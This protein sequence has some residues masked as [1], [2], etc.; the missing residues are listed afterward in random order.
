MTA[1]AF[2]RAWLLSPAPESRRQAAWGQRYQAWLAFR[3]NPITGED[4]LA[5]WPNVD[6]VVALTHKTGCGMAQGEPLSLTA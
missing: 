1:K 5:A 6:G 2:S 3:R 4:P